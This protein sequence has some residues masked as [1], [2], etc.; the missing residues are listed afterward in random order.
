[1]QDDADTCPFPPPR[2]PDLALE[3]PFDERPRAHA[4]GC[5]ELGLALSKHL[6]G[7]PIKI[8]ERDFIMWARAG[9]APDP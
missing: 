8:S 1:M 9:A 5:G 3:D 4:H 2:C 6:A 7:C